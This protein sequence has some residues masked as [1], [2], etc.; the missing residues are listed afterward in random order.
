MTAS[1]DDLV[2]SASRRQALFGLGAMS[3][4]VAATT[5]TANAQ[6]SAGAPLAGK[7]AIVTGARNNLGRGIAVA[8]GAMG[9]SV[10]AHYHRAETKA[11]ADETA[12]M[13]TKA[14]GKVA[15]F[16]G[17]LTRPEA[18]RAMYDLAA[19]QF[20]GV[21]IV[22][23]NVGAIIKKPLADFTDA[24]F[25]RLDAVNNRSLFYSLR[26]AAKRIRDNG[27]IINMGT[28]L[29]AGAAP[30]YTIYSG[31]KAPVEEYSRMLGKE[32]AAKKVTVNVIG[33]GPVDTPFF[34]GAEN[35]QSVQY[36]TGLSNERRLG[37]VDD[38]VPLIAFLARPEAQW[39][40]GQTLWINGGYL[41]R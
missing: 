8:L 16:Q 26:E 10:V 1:Q 25:E 29:L 20:G 4:L 24:E 7:V 32:L 21:D 41:T 11:E 14:G 9:A 30:G 34:H 31:T 35:P 12:S 38:I 13:V 40:N 5:G 37:K 33:P 15:L 22:S 6:A 2:P 27:R 28:S 17:D 23:N 3:A 36:A 18:V 39:I 19:N